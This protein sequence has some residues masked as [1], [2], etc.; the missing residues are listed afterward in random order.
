MWASA[1]YV[2]RHAA[3]MDQHNAVVVFDM[4]AGRTS[5]FFLNGRANTALASSLVW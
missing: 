1:E 2:L 5:G 4:G 3:E